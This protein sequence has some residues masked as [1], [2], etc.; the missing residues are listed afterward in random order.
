MQEALSA[1]AA[2]VY[3][4][5]SKLPGPTLRT[6]W[7]IADSEQPKGQLNETE[8]YRAC[9]LVALAQAGKTMS[10]ATIAAPAGLPNL[11][12]PGPSNAGAGLGESEI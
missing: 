5:R 12:P 11:P 2:L 7:A 6:M 4:T 3:F 1:K 10:A 8:F 9:K